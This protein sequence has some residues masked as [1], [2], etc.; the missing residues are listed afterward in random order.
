MTS[1]AS[2]KPSAVKYLA[3]LAAEL[4]GRLVNV[5]GT[6][7]VVGWWFRNTKL[8][9]LAQLI[10]G[11][12]TAWILAASHRWRYL[13]VS[14]AGLIAVKETSRVFVFG[15]GYS[16]N[17]LSE[18]ELRNIRNFDCI[19]FNG[20][21]HLATIPFKYF[22]L[23]AGYETVQG[24]LDWRPYAEYALTKIAS[25]PQLD[26]AIFLFPRGFTSSFTNRIVGYRL[27][28]QGKQIYYYWTDRISRRPNRNL[29]E[30][31][32]QRMGTLCTVISFAVAMEYK[33]IV[34]IGVDLYDSRYFWVPDNKT[35]NWSAEE[36]REIPSE[37][38]VRGILASEPHNTVNNGVIKAIADWG[39][40]L[41]ENYNVKLFVYN[42]KS[43]LVPHIPIFHWD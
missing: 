23:R 11:H 35:V 41:S 8:P 42:P 18:A 27:W 5:I 26:K 15:S 38:T 7:R 3:S 30:G 24:V 9:D 14:K 22:L 32:V 43:L 34:L 20:A 19:G 39:S 10:R 2:P 28:D 40:Y 31:L 36:K 37:A 4:K 6:A 17:D 13:T 33:E 29:E 21:F 25:N 1:M 16:L 12:L